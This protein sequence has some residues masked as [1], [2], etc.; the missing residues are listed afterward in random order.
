M[1]ELEAIAE[2]RCVD[3]VNDAKDGNGVPVRLL[4]FG[5]P[6]AD[7]MREALRELLEMHIGQVTFVGTF[8]GESRPGEAE[9]AYWD[10][11][12]LLARALA[13]LVRYEDNP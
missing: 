4:P 8:V 9:A 6:T 12:A 7:N 10:N 3:V 1:K 11:V 2:Q 13:A 5:A